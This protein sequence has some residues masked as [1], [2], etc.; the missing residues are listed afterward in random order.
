MCLIAFAW[1]AHPDYLLALAANRDEFHARPTA[2]LGAWS[3]LPGVSGGRD[4]REGGGWLALHRNGRLAAVT[5][6]REPHLEPAPRS[7]GELVQEF[8]AGHDGAADYA[9]RICAAGDAYGPHN[10][11][12]WDGGALVHASNRFSPPW[13]RIPPGVHGISN[14]P[15]DA[16][17]PKTLRLNAA[18][19]RWLRAQRGGEPELAPLLEALA[20]EHG[21]ADAELPHTG[22]SQE[23]ERML[24]PPFIRGEAYG[25]RAS[26]VLL[27]R[28]DGRTLLFERS[29]KPRKEP[30][31]DVRLE[32]Q[33]RMETAA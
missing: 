9:A 3:D 2:P 11:L 27:I 32:L 7:R 16:P 5:N 1:D 30:A 20:D 10:T 15:F 17:W 25:T 13:R 23:M 28:R 8:L 29:F 19:E 21:A 22:V 12:L 18:L 6:V 14:G 4:L 26:S 24:A 33:L 31:G